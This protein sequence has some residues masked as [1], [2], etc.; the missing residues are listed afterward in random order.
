MPTTP[1]N[2]KFPTGG[3]IMNKYIIGYTAT[4]GTGLVN[5]DGTDDH[6][7]MESTEG[8]RVGG[9][10]AR[11]KGERYTYQTT[12]DCNQED[13]LDLYLKA[14]VTTHIIRTDWE[15]GEEKEL[16]TKNRPYPMVHGGST[17]IYDGR[18]LCQIAPPGGEHQAP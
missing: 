6:M 8:S 17:R 7:Q 16:F 12:Y 14:E 15:T 13:W 4:N 3:F 1:N 2:Q 9:G 18:Y 11:R 5:M 10:S